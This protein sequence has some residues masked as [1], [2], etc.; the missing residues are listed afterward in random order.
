MR[1]RELAGFFLLLNLLYLPNL[2]RCRL[3]ETNGCSARAFRATDRK[4]TERPLGGLKLDTGARGLLHAPARGKGSVCGGNAQGE[5]DVSAFMEFSGRTESRT[6]NS[7]F[8]L[9]RNSPL[10]C[11]CFFY[12]F[13]FF[14]SL[15]FHSHSIIDKRRRVARQSPPRE[16]RATDAP[17]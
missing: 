3:Q 14:A 2:R 17:R 4:L 10:F 11:C 9:R 8:L 12:S 16:N 6:K 7:S 5:T 13:F 15:Y 1:A